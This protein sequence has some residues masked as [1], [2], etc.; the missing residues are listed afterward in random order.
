MN[1]PG[2]SLSSVGEELKVR[3][4]R[5]SS[6]LLCVTL[7]SLSEPTLKQYEAERRETNR[8][9]LT[10]I[11]GLTELGSEYQRKNHTLLSTHNGF[12]MTA[13]VSVCALHAD[14][15]VRPMRA[16]A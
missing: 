15:C 1:T 7:P 6:S 16:T 10:L 2:D 11:I 9:P 5:H 12:F 14:I 4:V 8:Q 3:W 13:C